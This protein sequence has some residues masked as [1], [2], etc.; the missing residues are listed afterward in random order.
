MHS[1][2]EGVETKLRRLA[3]KAG[4]E[5]RFQFTSLFHLMN[6]ELLLGGF[7]RL[8]HDATVG[9]DGVRCTGV[10]RCACW[11]ASAHDCCT[12]DKRCKAWFQRYSRVE[13]T[14]RWAGSTSA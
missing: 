12:S 3:E 14:R 4:R 10:T 9:I 5:P 7:E 8:R 13:A 11:R 6:K 1:N 2:E